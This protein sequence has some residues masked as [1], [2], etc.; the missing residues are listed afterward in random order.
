MIE[1]R[2]IVYAVNCSPMFCAIL[3]AAFDVPL[4]LRRTAPTYHGKATITSD[5]LVMCDCV[6]GDGNGRPDAFVCS[7]ESLLENARNLDAHINAHFE[8]EW[9]DHVERAVRAWIDKDWRH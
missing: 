7:W 4:D 8:N 1:P 9:G 3:D 2:G 6:D 5:G